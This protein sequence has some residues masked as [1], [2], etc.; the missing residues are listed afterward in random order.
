MSNKIKEIYIKNRTF[1]FF[2]GI[3]NIKN[4][5]ADKIKVDVDVAHWICDSKKPQLRKN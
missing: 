5:D 2:D 3:I 1:W 4:L